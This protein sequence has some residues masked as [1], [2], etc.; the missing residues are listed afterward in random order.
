MKPYLDTE[1]TYYFNNKHTYYFNNNYE[2]NKEL[3]KAPKII[4][5]LAELKAEQNQIQMI[6]IYG[7]NVM[8]E[9]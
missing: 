2:L 1:D 7:N 4:T 6:T 5:N 9:V 8:N 3:I